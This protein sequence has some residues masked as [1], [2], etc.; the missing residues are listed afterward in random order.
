M[1]VA[2]EKI[3][4]AAV[5]S[6]NYALGTL[7]RISKNKRQSTSILTP[8]FDEPKKNYVGAHIGAPRRIL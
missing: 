4:H 5:V 8:V 3:W 6:S 1:T 2:T 7:G